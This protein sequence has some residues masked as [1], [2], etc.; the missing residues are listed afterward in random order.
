[1]MTAGLGWLSF[2]DSDLHS[3][4]SCVLVLGFGGISYSGECIS[5]CS[6]QLAGFSSLT[7]L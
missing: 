3:E 7:T 5:V 4:V 2:G 1:M 6:W